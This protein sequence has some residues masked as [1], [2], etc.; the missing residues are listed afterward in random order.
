MSTP[1]LEKAISA[2]K[3]RGAEKNILEIICKMF[4]VD[5]AVVQ[6]VVMAWEL[7]KDKKL[8]HGTD[9]QLADMFDGLGTGEHLDFK[10]VQAIEHMAARAFRR[11]AIRWHMEQGLHLEVPFDKLI[12]YEQRSRICNGCAWQLECVRDMLSTP[13]QCHQG[14][15]I[16]CKDQ[17]D[18][19]KTRSF[20]HKLAGVVPIKLDDATVTVTAEHPRGT[21]VVPIMDVWI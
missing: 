4:E 12:P 11:C 9:G 7:L 19:N 18:R 6:R 16:I 14:K 21:Y 15:W 2:S 5:A 17:P 1:E 20:Q 10:V 13:E 8:R 3:W